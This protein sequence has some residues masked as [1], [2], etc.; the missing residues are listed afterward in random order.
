MVEPITNIETK[1]PVVEIK[2]HKYPGFIR[3]IPGCIL[4]VTDLFSVMQE[5]LP[6]LRFL[7]ELE[8]RVYRFESYYC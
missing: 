5:A 1:N 7:L 6:V 8:I 2:L 4:T 3:I